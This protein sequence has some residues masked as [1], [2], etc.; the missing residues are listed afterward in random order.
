VTGI[1]VGYTCDATLCTDPTDLALVK[2]ACAGLEPPP[3]ILKLEFQVGYGC[4]A[5]Q[6][7]GCEPNKKTN[8]KIY[9][10]NKAQKAK[11]IK[12]QC[13]IN[14]TLC[15]KKKKGGMGTMGSMGMGGGMGMGGMGGM[16]MSGMGMGKKKKGG[17]GMGMVMGKKKTM[18][19][20]NMT[21]R[22]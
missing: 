17:T 14:N 10:L 3:E 1:E 20:K 19:K 22:R 18:T 6:L 13:E 8:E 7:C 16:G 12:T 4:A 9:D 5:S 11:G 15:G 2:D 21:K